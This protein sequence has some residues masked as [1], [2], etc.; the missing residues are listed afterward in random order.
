MAFISESELPEI[1]FKSFGTNVSI[2][3]KASIYNP[4]LIEIGNNVRIDD[5]VILSPTSKGIKIGN[6]VHIGC[7]SSLIGRGLITIN[8]YSGTSGRVCIYS[9]NDD[10]SGN[11]MMGPTLPEEFTNITIGD[12]TIGKHVPIGAGSIILPNVVIEDGAVIGALSLVRKNVRSFTINQGN[13]LRALGKRNRTVLELEEEF[14]SKFKT[15]S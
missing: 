2:S 10:Y 14:K 9:S 1:G 13:P 12:V 3:S 8:D 11:F 6:Y 15:E 4:H 5:F 7:Y